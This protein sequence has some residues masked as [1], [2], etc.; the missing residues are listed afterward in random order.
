MH[1]L[2]VYATNSSGTR[3]AA[4]IAADVLEKKGHTVTVQ[5]AQDTEAEHISAADFVVLGSCT[6]EKI[7][8]DGKRSEGELQQYMDDLKQRLKDQKFPGK[9][10]A[11]FGLGDSSYSDFCAAAPMMEFMIHAWGGTLKAPTLKID[12]F[13]FHL[14][15]NRQRV[16]DWADHVLSS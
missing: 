15:E 16:K 7:M 11:V 9:R 3:Q 6:W 5:R 2:I 8:P 1:V 12:G 13:F 10:F 4:E 14:P